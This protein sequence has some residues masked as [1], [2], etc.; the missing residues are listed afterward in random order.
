MA[1]RVNAAWQVLGDA[2]RRARYDRA[3]REVAPPPRAPARELP[4]PA[5]GTLSAI[6]DQY[7]A[8][9]SVR[10]PACAQQFTAMVGAHLV[11]RPQLEMRFLAGRYRLELADG[12]G[13]AVGGPC[14]APAHRAGAGRGRDALAR[15]PA[16]RSDGAVHRRPRRAHRHRLEG[17]MSAAPVIGVCAPLQQARWGVWDLP[18]VVVAANYL[19][20]AWAEGARTLVIPPD[21]ALIDDPRA[22]LERIDGLLLLG[23]ADVAAD[24]YGAVPHPDSEPP[25]HAR[26]AVEI[27]LVRAAIDAGVPTLG[28]CR[29]LQIINVALWRHPA[30]ALARG[31]RQS[32]A[33]TSART[34][35]GQRARGPTHARV[36]RRRRDGRRAPAGGLA[37]PSGGR[38][39]GRGLAGDRVLRGWHH[40]GTRAA[41]RLSA[42]CPVASRGGSGQPRD[43]EPR[44]GCP[45]ARRTGGRGTTNLT[46]DQRGGAR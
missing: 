40:R 37:P 41:R 16:R 38:R 5:C 1:Q 2:D 26:D 20:A 13:S 32:G 7:G 25:Q 39:V 34:V 23:G 33:P 29:G 31:A 19:E 35:H 4:C 22:V 43:Q 18:A 24:R 15:V 12:C 9:A 11:G 28:I 30:P 17:R 6:A 36:A 27:A 3:R 21:P 14:P 45:R 44:R 10:C 8:V 42:R 46:P